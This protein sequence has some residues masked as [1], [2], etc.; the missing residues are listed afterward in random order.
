MEVLEKFKDSLKEYQPMLPAVVPS[1]VLCET[2]FEFSCPHEALHGLHLVEVHVGLE[3][4]LDLLSLG[5]LG[6]DSVQDEAEERRDQAAEA[7]H[8]CGSAITN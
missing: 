6:D 5:D 2:Y 8:H 3:G 4:V 7:G 1:R